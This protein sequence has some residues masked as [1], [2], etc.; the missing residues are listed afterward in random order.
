MISP[1]VTNPACELVVTSVL[2]APMTGGLGLGAP[3]N[4][5]AETEEEELAV[6]VAA[7]DP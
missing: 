1:K 4:Q 7:A 6:D 5:S 3:M 2:S